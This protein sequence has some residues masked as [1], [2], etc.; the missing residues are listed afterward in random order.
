MI[1]NFFRILTNDYFKDIER[2]REE[3]WLARSTDL[4]DLERRQ[5]ELTYG[6]GNYKFFNE[7]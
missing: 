6:S 2:R 3:A 4:V 7:R 1:I 5:R